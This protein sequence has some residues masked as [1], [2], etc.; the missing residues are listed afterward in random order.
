MNTYRNLNLLN[1]FSYEILKKKI[2]VKSLPKFKFEQQSTIKVKNFKK[3]V[4]FNLNPG[5]IVQAVKNYEF[6]NI[7]KA[8]FNDFRFLI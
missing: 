4:H 3:F 8:F 6:F 2:T 5:I 7:S 1:K